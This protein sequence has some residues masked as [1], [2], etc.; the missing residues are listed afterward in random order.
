MLNFYGKI[1]KIRVKLLIQFGFLL[2]LSILLMG[3]TMY[4]IMRIIKYEDTRKTS[5]EL[6]NIILQMRRAE[7]DF[8]LREL[9]NETFFE[10]AESKYVT[11]HDELSAAALVKL[12]IIM[13]SGTAGEVD[14]INMV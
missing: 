3:V 8:M 10:K 5:Q 6:D 2:F 11:K 4:S 9:T 13:N 12:E 1:K 14:S 7:K